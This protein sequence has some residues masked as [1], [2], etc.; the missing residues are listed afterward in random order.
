MRK[1]AILCAFFA[2][3]LILF[4]LLFFL[5]AGSVHPRSVWISY[6]WIQF[7]FIL[8]I[9][10]PW[11]ARRTENG[12]VYK[13]TLALISGVYCLVE[14]V[15]GLVVIILHPASVRWPIV[16]QVIPFCL[17]LFVLLGNLLFIEFA[18]DSDER[19]AAKEKAEKEQ[20]AEPENKE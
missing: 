16:V 4:N 14:F 10:T 1:R 7:A 12:P 11:L 17:Y 15:V 5:I 3:P 20:K 6:A 18:A 8:L 9:V 2:I 13:I 19:H